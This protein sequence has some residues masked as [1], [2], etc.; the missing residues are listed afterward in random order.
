EDFVLEVFGYT[1][2]YVSG[3]AVV[4]FWTM[5]GFVKR[6]AA[7][8]YLAAVFVVLGAPIV[9]CGAFWIRHWRRSA[10]FTW[11]AL[12]LAAVAGVSILA[13]GRVYLYYLQ[14]AIATLP[15]AGAVLTHE[16][17]AS[18][19]ALKAWAARRRPWH[20]IAA[21]VLLMAP[22]AVWNALKSPAYHADAA[23]ALNGPRF[24]SPRMLAFATPDPNARLVVFGYMSRFYVDSQLRPGTR[25]TSPENM[26]MDRPHRPEYWRRYL[27][28]FDA[29]RPEIFIDAIRPGSFVYVDPAREGPQTVPGLGDRIARRYDQISAAQDA[30]CSQLY[31]RKDIAASYRARTAAIASITASA[32]LQTA[33]GAYEARH[34]VDRHIFEDC[35]DR[36]LGQT[37]APGWLQMQLAAPQRVAQVSL[38][39]T[40]GGYR[41]PPPDKRDDFLAQAESVADL[42]AA[43]HA[44]IILMNGEEIVARRR[45]A[46]DGYPYWTKADFA[47]APLASAV[48]IEFPD[49]RGHGPGLNEVVVTTPAP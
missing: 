41:A 20:A 32:A 4:W 37:G 48:R 1:G 22:G 26:I 39:N 12:G 11:L 5:V 8:P 25:E 40:R 28:E 10:V 6:I 18:A 9:V 13:P 17:F 49:W 47:D 2:G 38:L 45:V 44:E 30:A 21:I 34:V 24:H 15:L 16:A 23:L 43:R 7:D 19:P 35:V 29:S 14:F 33:D 42:R 27:E 3:G 31:L 46:V 36:W